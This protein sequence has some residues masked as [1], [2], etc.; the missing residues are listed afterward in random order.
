[1]RKLA[2]SVSLMLVFAGFGSCDSCDP[3]RPGESCSQQSD[4]R[5]GNYCA[6]DGVCKGQS[7][8]Y[9]YV[10][11]KI[12]KQLTF[13]IDYV[14]GQLP[15]QGALDVLKSRLQALGISGHVKKPEGV[16]IMIDDTLPA[17]VEADHAY[18]FNELDALISSNKNTRNAGKYAAAYLL[19]VDGHF[20]EDTSSSKVLGFAYGGDSIVIFKSTITRLCNT[21]LFASEVCRVSEA[22]VLLH[23]FGHLM[24]LVN[25]GLSMASNH[26]DDSHGSHDSNAACVMHWTL[27]NSEGVTLLLNRIIS[28]DSGVP[29]FDAAC[30]ADMAQANALP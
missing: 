19:Y 15:N 8:P 13:E 18:T 27:E 20:A 23:E 30:L 11:D 10:T 14:Q 2:L 1:M 25:N 17:H 12:A 26:Q 21:G 6:A 9:L 5:S 16:E 24:G 29:S 7:E 28:G 22:S 3:A 4:C